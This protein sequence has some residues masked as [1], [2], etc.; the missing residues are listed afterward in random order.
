MTIDYEIGQEVFF[1]SC[2]RVEKRAIEQINITRDGIT[3]FGGGMRCRTTEVATSP[4][5]LFDGLEAGAKEEYDRWM[6]D[7][8]EQRKKYQEEQE[9]KQRR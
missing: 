6:A 2:G 9:A 1:I 3:L 5:V 7:I 4:E 8:A